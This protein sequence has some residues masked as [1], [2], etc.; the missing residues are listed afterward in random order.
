MSAAGTA[1]AQIITQR[2]DLRKELR[3][4]QD[5]TERLREFMRDICSAA[6]AQVDATGSF[7]SKTIE[8]IYALAHGALHDD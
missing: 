6:W 5:E 2:D 3:A 7:D 8:T 4:A 1:V